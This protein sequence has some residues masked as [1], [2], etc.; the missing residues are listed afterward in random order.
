MNNDFW[1]LKKIDFCC[2]MWNGHLRTP[3]TLADKK[4]WILRKEDRIIDCFVDSSCAILNPV[5][6]QNGFGN[7]HTTKFPAEQHFSQV[8]DNYTYPSRVGQKIFLEDP[9]QGQKGKEL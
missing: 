5:K 6:G 3:E 7:C 2:I 1:G 9:I 8:S 4:I